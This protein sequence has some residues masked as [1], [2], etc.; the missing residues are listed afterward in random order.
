MRNLKQRLLLLALVTSLLTGC[1]TGN[2][3]PACVCPPMIKYDRDF[4]KKLATEIAAM[5]ENDAVISV[6][7]DYA[8]IRK[9][10]AVCQ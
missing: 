7:Q 1:A 9:Q 2:S 8:L 6:M 4:Q 10:L 5:N 3:D